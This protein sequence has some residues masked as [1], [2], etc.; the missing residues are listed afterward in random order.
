MKPKAVAIASLAL[1]LILSLSAWTS[2][3]STSLETRTIIV[4]GDA[5]VRVVPDE[6]LLTLGV[7]TW[8]KNL[9]QAKR[10]NDEIVADV[11]ALVLGPAEERVCCTE[12]ACPHCHS[13]Q[14]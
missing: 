3:Q 4:T 14:R 13:S 10:E 8:D 7:Q 2:S 1:V 12:P 6:V 9:D 5:E 11:L